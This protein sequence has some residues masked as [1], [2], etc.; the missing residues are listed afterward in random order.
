MKNLLIV[1]PAYREHKNILKLCTKILNLKSQIYKFKIL[2]VDDS[3][4]LKTQNLIRNC[5]LKKNI[6]FKKRFKKSGRGSAVLS[7]MNFFLSKKNNFSFFVEMDA[8]LS[9]NPDELIRNLNHF[10]FKNLDLLIASRYIKKSK[11][12]NW[13]ISRKIL[14]Y[15]SNMLARLLLKIPASDYTNGY[16]IYSR[17]AVRCCVKNCGKIGDGF[18]ILSEFLL[19]I[20]YYKMKIDEINTIFKNRIRGKSSVSKKEIFNSLIG[21]IKLYKIKKLLN[22][23]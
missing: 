11:I 15:F 2:I 18:I 21:L 7:G 17:R 14:S 19:Y 9:H 5:T 3:E 10:N 8:D 6:F 20:H 16:R 12:L 13:P 4:D 1:I 22:Q 23:N